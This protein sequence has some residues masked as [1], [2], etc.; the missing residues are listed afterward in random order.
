[1][2]PGRLAQTSY[3]LSTLRLNLGKTVTKQP[4]VLWDEYIAA[5]RD[6]YSYFD[7]H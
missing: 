4:H 1:L 7:V 5:N 2:L 3:P 6:G